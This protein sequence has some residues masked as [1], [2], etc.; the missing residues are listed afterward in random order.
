[1]P[2]KHWTDVL[3]IP[4]IVLIGAVL[5]AIL[6]PVFA[7]RPSHGH[8]PSCITHLRLCTTALLIYQADFDDKNPPDHW[9][10]L[11]MP[12]TKN[13]DYYTCPAVALKG[14][15]NGYAM[16]QALASKRATAFAHPDATVMVFE[17]ANLTGDR[18]APLSEQVYRDHYGTTVTYVGYMDSHVKAFPK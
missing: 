15:K 9:Q 18:Y 3:Q 7:H 11:T 6:W 14:L 5:M 13:P 1:M 17:S 10:T 12:Y 4:L 2:N 8:R 16:N